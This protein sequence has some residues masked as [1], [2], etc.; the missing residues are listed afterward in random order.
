M[1]DN[2]PSRRRTLLSLSFMP[3]EVTKTAD[4]L[5]SRRAQAG[6]AHLPA[7]EAKRLMAGSPK[8][9]IFALAENADFSESFGAL[10]HMTALLVSDPKTLVPKIDEE[11][12]AWDGHLDG[13]HAALL[14]LARCERRC[15]P[16]VAAEAVGSL[17]RQARVILQEPTPGSAG[18]RS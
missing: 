5:E 16:E 11:R 3:A 7:G 6:Q 1:S 8:A 10:L 17:L 15:A 12:I 2:P 14:C 18:T 9:R 13:L 4:N